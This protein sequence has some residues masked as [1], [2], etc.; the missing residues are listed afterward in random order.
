MRVILN[1]VAKTH[2]ATCGDNI[3]G[4]PPVLIPNTE[5]KPCRADGTCPDTDR[6]SRTSP[7]FLFLGS[8]VGSSE[9]LLTARSLVRVQQGEPSCTH[10]KAD[11]HKKD[12][13]YSI[14]SFLFIK[15]CIKCYKIE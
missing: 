11:V 12:E 13:I 8:S 9:R 5:V 4:D 15:N 10:K 3:A 7:H 2:L 6:E 1:R 14:S